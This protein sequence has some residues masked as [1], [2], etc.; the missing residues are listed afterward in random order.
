MQPTC[1]LSY[2]AILLQLASHSV[3]ALT[4]KDNPCA[5]SY[6]AIIAF[7]DSLS[8][9]GNGSWKISNATWPANPSYYGGRFS[10]GL[11]WI[12]YVAANLSI[13]LYNYAVGGATTSNSLVQGYT[14]PGSSIPV[15]SIQDQVSNFLK[16]SSSDIPDASPLFV[17][18]GGANDVLFNPNVTAAQSYQEIMASRSALLAH[19]PNATFMVLDYPDLSR[20]PYAYYITRLD[21]HIIRAFS[22]GLTKLYADL[23]SDCRTDGSS[24][25]IFVNLP[26]LFNQWE[27]YAEPRDYGFDAL[28]AYGSCLVG[29]Y[30][31]TETVSLCSDP[32]SKVF[33]DEYHPTTRAHSFIAEKVLDALG[34]SGRCRM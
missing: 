15:P 31:E 34:S 28:G 30:K 25:L 6:S 12:E 29:V 21:K 5:A 1:G 26:Q 17:L 11:V 23:S 33:W 24:R 10:N 20:I 2:L 13:P 16:H 7:G 18:F 22:Q 4:G 14:G 8:D 27:Y 3:S 32:S 19:F 9:T